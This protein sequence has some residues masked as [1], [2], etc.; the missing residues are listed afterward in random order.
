[1]S[2]LYDGQEGDAK[3][4]RLYGLKPDAGIQQILS[5]WYKRYH[6]GLSITTVT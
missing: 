2:H 1:M 3:R 6:H 5:S 4:V